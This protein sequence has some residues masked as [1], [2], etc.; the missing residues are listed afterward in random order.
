VGFLFNSMC[1]ILVLRQRKD[2]LE[3]PISK[4]ISDL[5]DSWRKDNL[6]S[7]L[8]VQVQIPNPSCPRILSHIH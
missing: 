3:V 8:A 4:S 7:A 6:E 1:G 2:L 5:L